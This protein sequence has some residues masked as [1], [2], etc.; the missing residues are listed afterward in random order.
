MHRQAKPVR[1]KA[2]G[3]VKRFAAFAHSLLGQDA[4]EEI[5]PEVVERRRIVGKQPPRIVLALQASRI[6]DLGRPRL[7]GVVVDD[8]TWPKDFLG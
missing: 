3:K 8:L 2:K 5:F 7:G 1:A 6:G 4:I